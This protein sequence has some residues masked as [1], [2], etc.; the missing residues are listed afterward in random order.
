MQPIVEMLPKQKHF[1]SAAASSHVP[2]P[3]SHQSA[4]PER[5]YTP[6]AVAAV[7]GIITKRYNAIVDSFQGWISSMASFVCWG[8][9]LRPQTWFIIGRLLAH[10]P[11]AA[12]SNP[13]LLGLV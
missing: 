4:A 9:Q 12:P 6:R 2:F 8:L 13:P 1:I 10:R 7:M 5:D 11:K 3:P